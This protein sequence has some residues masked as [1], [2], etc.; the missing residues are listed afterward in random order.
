[1][2]YRKDLLQAAGITDLSAL[3]PDN[4]PPT[5]D[6]VRAMANKVNHKTGGAYDVVG[7]IP[8]INQGWHYT[9]GFVYGGTLFDKTGCKVTANDPKIVQASTDIFCNRSTSLCSGAGE[10]I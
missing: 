4:G 2:S 8:W 3:D 7:F 9:W 1:M 6:T 10:S 5:I